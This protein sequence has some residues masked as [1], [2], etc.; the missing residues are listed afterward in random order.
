MRKWLYLA[1]FLTS[2][3][4]WASDLEGTLQNLVNAFV[5]RLLPIVSLG[6]L[7]KNIFGHIQGDPNARNETIRVVIAI[8]CLIAINGVWAYI[9]QQAR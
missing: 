2:T 5:G 7:G 9:S 6:Y 3:I 8:A 1:L 4:A